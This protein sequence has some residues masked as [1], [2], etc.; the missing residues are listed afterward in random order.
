METFKINTVVIDVF[1]KKRSILLNVLK[2]LQFSIIADVYR[3]D[4]KCMLFC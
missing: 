1:Q 3:K 4:F 2:G